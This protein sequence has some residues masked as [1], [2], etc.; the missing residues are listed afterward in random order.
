MMKEYKTTIHECYITHV[1]PPTLDKPIFYAET[2]SQAISYLENKGG[3]VYNN[4]LHNFSHG[5]YGSKE[6]K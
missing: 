1:D 6:L 3:G 2:Y 5:V 4:P